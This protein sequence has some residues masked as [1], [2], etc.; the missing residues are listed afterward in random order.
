M[1]DDS[2]LNGELIINSDG[3]KQNISLNCPI[4]NKKGLINIPKSLIMKSFGLTCVTIAPNII[5][6]HIFQIF[7]DKQY[8]IRGYGK[9]DYEIGFV[10]L[11]AEKFQKINKNTIVKFI[12]DTPQGEIPK[13][14][15]PIIS[16]INGLR[17][18]EEII[19]V[20]EQESKTVLEI[21]FELKSLKLIEFE[22]VIEDYD[23]PFLT[24]KGKNLLI[25]SD[26]DRNSFLTSSSI[27]SNFALLESKKFD[28]IKNIDS[29]NNICIIGEKCGIEPSVLK[30]LF[31]GLKECEYID[32]LSEQLKFCLIFE[33]FYL[34]FSKSI[35]KFLGNKGVKIFN[36]VLEENDNAFTKLIKI[37]ED[38]TYSFEVLK[39]NIETQKELFYQEIIKIFIKPIIITFEKIKPALSILSTNYFKEFNE[40]ILSVF[41]D[42]KKSYSTNDINILSQ[43]WK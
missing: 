27:L 34:K 4:C 36:K 33:D 20:S 23:I 12:E 39:S 24:E 31:R 15:W 2:S 37:K 42:L 6:E 11:E 38:G 14:Y 9:S 43:Y 26:L 22:I 32:L 25:K 10:E 30:I 17:N 18:I 16:K 5:C 35:E 8:K 3:S 40:R 21:L 1:L 41:Y 29:R 13:E 28:L 19:K 7:L